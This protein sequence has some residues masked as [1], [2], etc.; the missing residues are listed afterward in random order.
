MSRRDEGYQVRPFPKIR[1]AYLDIMAVGRRRNLIH[2]LVEVD[3][4]EARRR[5]HG[6]EA[7]T[8]VRLSF[9][10]FLI[11]CV[12]RAVAADRL[13]HAYRRGRRLILFD[14]VDVNTQIEAEAE[15]QTIVQSM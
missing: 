4:T 11:H 6:Y 5:L 12:A 13:V 2:G 8:G 9:T 7:V 15:G 14:D 3:V 1:R 10:A